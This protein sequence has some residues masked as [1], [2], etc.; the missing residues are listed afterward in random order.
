MFGCAHIECRCGAHFCFACLEPMKKC[1]GQCENDDF[2]DDD[3]T[4]DDTD[5]EDIDALVAMN[6]TELDLGVEPYNPTVDTW[7]CNH[8]FKPIYKVY[9]YLSN[10]RILNSKNQNSSSL[11]CQICWKVLSPHF[12]PTNTGKV[13]HAVVNLTGTPGILDRP[14]WAPITAEGEP[15]WMC[16]GKHLLCYGCPRDTMLDAKTSKYSSECGAFCLECAEVIEGD[17]MQL[18]EGGENKKFNL[19]YDCDCGMIV[20]GACKVKLDDEMNEA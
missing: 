9:G 15:A 6:G 3:L 13:C 7:S 2:E 17:K 8:R 11:D 1:D 10:G 12:P 16:V 20:C 19:A 14:G 18:K 5:L 4:D